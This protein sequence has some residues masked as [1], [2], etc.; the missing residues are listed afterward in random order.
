MVTC[1][2]TKIKSLTR[3]GFV[4]NVP[5]MQVI[6]ASGSKYRQALLQQMG[7]AF[8]VRLPEVDEEKAKE[9]LIN[10]LER[11][12][13]LSELKGEA[14]TKLWPQALVI[15]SDQVAHL[16]G[17]ILSK[18]KTAKRAHE[19]L[20]LL[21]GRT[22]ELITGLW[23]HHPTYGP[24]LDVVTAQMKMRSLHP[25]QIQ[26]YVEQDQ[27]LD[28]AGAYKWEQAGICLIEKMVCP[29]PTAII[30]LPLMSVT[31][32]L[33]AWNLPFPFAWTKQQ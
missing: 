9:N 21:Q 1:S 19:M 7:L 27:P 22:H 15:A 32:Q 18:P 2:E 13:R 4:W 17:H 31:Q 3:V 12:K 10:P 14:V 8:E 25:E 23:M 11:A 20:S 28:C 26:A 29:D 6:L 5:F 16:D 30:G 33:R 24:H